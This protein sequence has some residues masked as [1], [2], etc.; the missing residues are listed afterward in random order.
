MS[1]SVT[2]LKYGWL[3][4]A[5]L[6]VLTGVTIYISGN[7]RKTVQVEDVIP[8]ALGVHEHCLATQYSTNPVLYRVDP[9]SFVR[10]WYSNVYATNGVAVF[11]HT[12]T[13]TFGWEIDRAML[14][15]L[16]TTIKSLVPY[17]CDSNNTSLTVTGLWASLGIGDGT[18]QFTRTPVLGTN[19][20][21]YGD[22]PWQIYKEDLVER[23]K[24]LYSL[25]RTKPTVTLVPLGKSAGGIGSGSWANAQS[26]TESIYDG[27]SPSAG[28]YFSAAT[29][30]YSVSTNPYYSARGLMTRIAGQMYVIASTSLN[31]TAVFYLGCTNATPGQVVPSNTTYTFDAN[32]DTYIVEGYHL[33]DTQTNSAALSIG[34][35]NLPHP[36]WCSEPGINQDKVRG[37]KTYA[38]D[39]ILDWEFYYCTNKFW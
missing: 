13:N 15:S 23:Y 30:G 19:S 7:M 31:Y 29:A 8:I 39:I 36:T 10:T 11:T 9:P 33:A 12:V 35:T 4:L 20:A 26:D 2:Q 21:T 25:N 28:S 6:G 16:D 5:S 18:N 22:Y 14:V 24:V 27:L 3:A 1:L 32:S 17:Y 37:Y 34:N 38:H